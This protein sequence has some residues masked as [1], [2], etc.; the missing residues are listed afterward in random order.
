MIVIRSTV[1]VLLV[2]NKPWISGEGAQHIKTNCGEVFRRSE[3]Q[4]YIRQLLGSGE[5]EIVQYFSS[6]WSHRL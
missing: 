6:R 4:C 2:A 3:S 1:V 5:L